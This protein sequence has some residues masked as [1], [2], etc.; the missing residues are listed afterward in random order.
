MGEEV[1]S[2]FKF[3]NNKKQVKILSLDGGGIRGI[4]P[5]VIL[6][7]IEKRTGKKISECFDL[8][9]GTSTGGIL[10]SAL[11]SNS[12][13]SAKKA[14]DI[15]MKQG[16]TIFSRSVMQKL[17]FFS[18]L[19]DTKYSHKGLEAVLTQH[20]QK[21]TIDEVKAK[22]LI[23]A[24]D[25][26]NRESYFFKSWKKD[27]AGVPLVTACM[28]TSAAPTYFPPVHTYIQG[29]ERTFIDGG[30]YM[31]N[32]AVSAY[33]EAIR[34]YRDEENTEIDVFMLSLGTG[35]LTQSIPYD[36]AK[37]WGKIEWVA[38]L[39]DCMF[40]GDS[41]AVEYQMNML[42]GQNYVRLQVRDLDE[43]AQEM[44]VVEPDNLKNLKSLAD[45]LIKANSHLIDDICNNVL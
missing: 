6:V 41:D 43:K 14:L 22:L 10:A 5:A 8:I 35:Q 15:Y 4:I 11:C 27:C 20:F 3:D 33:V 36:S 9:T 1:V 13:I 30:V 32:P 34:H 44:D 7:E 17:W 18:S 45:K 19:S 23:P 16:Q 29:K 21:E 42:L 12:G 31:N 2:R 28:A 26:H 39:I 40:D 25:I 38:P 24:Y 37:N